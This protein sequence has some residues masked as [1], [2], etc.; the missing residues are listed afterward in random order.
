MEKVALRVLRRF[1]AAETGKYEL[2][3]DHLFG[4]R[5]PEGGSNCAKCRFV[6][7][8]GSHCANSY[9][10]DWRKSLGEDPTLL[11]MSADRY[12]CDVFQAT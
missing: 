5:V 11:P 7:E 3:P 4:M 1:L 12:C 10:Q 8:D 6:S 9:Y 2:P